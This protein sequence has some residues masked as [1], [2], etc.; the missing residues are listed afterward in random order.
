[1]TDWQNRYREEML[2]GQPVITGDAGAHHP[3]KKI[4]RAITEI[5]EKV[6]TGVSLELTGDISGAAEINDNVLS[7]NLEVTNQGGGT[8]D[9][10]EFALPDG[11]QAGMVLTLAISSSDERSAYWD[12]V[13]A[14]DAT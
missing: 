6:V 5:Q 7:I 11:G 14:V 13:R 8:G 10:V 4:A 9:A 3:G 12:W 2:S 1:M